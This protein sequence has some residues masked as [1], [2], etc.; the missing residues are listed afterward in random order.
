[1][2]TL[3]LD[4]FS[5]IS[6]DMFIGAMLDLGVDAH[7]LDHELDKL[8]LKEFHLHIYRDQKCGIEG[9]KFHV[10]GHEHDG[11]HH[12]HEA[13]HDH[14]H[15][16]DHHGHHHHHSE[17]AAHSHADHGH[18]HTHEHEHGRTFIDIRELIE[19]STL[20]PWVKEKAIAV[21]A[22]IAR[23]EG[24]IHGKPPEQVHFHEVGAIDSIV[25]IVGACVCLE[26]AGKPRVLAAPVV[27]GTGFVQCAHGRFPIPAP[28]T[29][30]I[31]AERQ[32]SISQC[33]ERGEFV[34]PT[35]AA[36]LAE[37]VEEFGPMRE[38]T[39]EKVG[40]GIGTRD[41]KTRPNVLRAIL[42][43]GGETPPMDWQTD[44]IA[45][46]ETNLDDL[47]PEVLGYVV[48]L[49]LAAG[50]LDIFHTPIQMKKNRPG[51]LLTILCAPERADQFTELLLRETTAL[52][53]RR[54]FTERRKL[55]RELVTVQTEYGEIP[56]KLGFLNGRVIQAAPEHDACRSVA[57]THKIPLK[58]VYAAAV[59]AFEAK[60]K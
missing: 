39:V 1:M 26:L 51:V 59:K 43:R 28:A 13:E 54:S 46:L 19:K 40:F 53:V 52:G 48:D 11:D 60:G 44:T 49:A 7:A 35:G 58:S 55:R 12:H 20:S 5:G 56:V 8:G 24:K 31:L 10:H 37:F 4:I 29:L 57:A 38:L 36:L 21:F 3:Y 47:S 16:H 18:A 41:N 32:V 22:R 9:T 25:D 2:K 15:E 23:A 17:K 33:E 30:N 45:V 14:G 34:T 42:G 6:G 50:A 27:E